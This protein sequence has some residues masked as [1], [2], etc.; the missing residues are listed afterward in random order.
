MSNSKHQPPILLQMRQIS[1]SFPG[2]KALSD[3]DFTVKRGQIHA[4]MGENGAGKSTLIKVLTGVYRKGTGR[5]VFDGKDINPASVQAAQKLGISTVYQEVN[6]VGSLSVAENIFLGRQPM[7]FA[8]IDWK[9]I[10]R[11]A[12]SALARL[13]LDIDVTAQL[14]SYSIAIQQMVAIARA[15]DI[16]AKLLILDEPTSCLDAGEVEQL[17]SVMRKL[18]DEGLGIIFVTHFIDQVYQVADCITVLRNGRLVGDYET[19]SLPRVEL[20]AKM[21]GRELVEFEVV[22]PDSRT[23][24]KKVEQTPFLQAQGLGKKGAI[25]P[26]DLQVFTGQVVGLAGLLGSGRT[27]L[28]RLIFGIDKAEKGKV[29]IEGKEVSLSSPA[30]AIDEGIG[31]CPEDRKTEGIIADLSV[32]ENIILALQANKGWLRYFSKKKQTEIADHYIRTLNIAATD[33][34]QPVKNLSGGNQQKVILARWLASDPTFLIL[35]EPTRGIDV[36]TKAEIQKLILSLCRQGKAVLFIS[37][38]LD[39]VVRC[40]SR[41]IVLRDRIKIAELTGKQIDEQVIMHTIAKG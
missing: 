23:H 12:R 20:I 2:V 39:E 13:N 1:K 31:F 22:A 35:D 9:Q 29:F 41:V 37:S 11:R 4:L 10:N 33:A 19:V 8:R 36:G 28:A 40:S 21:M 3:V 17:F 15:L 25:A 32:R 18:K 16:S 7:K 14:S 30:R 5:M 24:R 38:E 34:E 6:L 27:E 26:F